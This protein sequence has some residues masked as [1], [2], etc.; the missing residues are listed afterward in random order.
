MGEWVNKQPLPFTLSAPPPRAGPRGLETEGLPSG[1]AGGGGLA[2]AGVVGPGPRCGGPGCRVGRVPGRR[3]SNS[4]VCRVQWPGLVCGARPWAARAW[5]GGP[6]QRSGV[7]AAPA[8][9]RLGGP[10]ARAARARPALRQRELCA[11]PGARTAPPAPSCRRRWARP[12]GRGSRPRRQ[13]LPASRTPSPPRRRGRELLA[14]R[15]PL[16]ACPRPSLAPRQPRSPASA[17]GARAPRC[18]SSP[19]PCCPSSTPTCTATRP[20]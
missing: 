20:P 1:R 9:P 8:R 12:P 3:G 13:L 18:P 2:P 15:R 11:R 6:R 19:R 7:G 5:R 16:S 4:S 10:R 14:C 17:P